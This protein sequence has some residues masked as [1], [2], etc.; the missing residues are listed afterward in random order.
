[1][2]GEQGLSELGACFGY[3]CT[4]FLTLAH[5]GVLGGG[6][7]ARLYYYNREILRVDIRK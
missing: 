7:Y 1:M 2:R 4:I 3:A 6:I 5:G